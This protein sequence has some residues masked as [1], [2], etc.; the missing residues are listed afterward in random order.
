M[1]IGK[2]TKQKSLVPRQKKFS[3]LSEIEFYQENVLTK[4]MQWMLSEFK[5]LHLAEVVI[6]RLYENK[7][8]FSSIRFQSIIYIQTNM[9]L[10]FVASLHRKKPFFTVYLQLLP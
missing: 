8:I 1:P 5:L 3:K 10:I 4:F 7:N 6:M 2:I 9:I